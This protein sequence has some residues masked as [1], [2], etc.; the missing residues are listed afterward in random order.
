M[1]AK[2]NQI[3]A[4]VNRRMIRRMHKFGIEVPST[5]EEAY[6][7]DRINENTF[8]RDT[9]HKEMTNVKVAFQFPSDDENLPVGYSKLGGTFNLRCQNGFDKKG[10]LCGWWASHGSTQLNDLC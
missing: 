1:I 3:V 7:L 8:W 6:A 10:S 5:V 2:K 4:A 9:I